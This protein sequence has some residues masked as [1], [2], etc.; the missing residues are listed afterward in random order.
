MPSPY[1]HCVKK[2]GILDEEILDELA[3]TI[4]RQHC[5]L[6]I[7]LGLADVDEKLPQRDLKEFL[8]RVV[9]WCVEN[10]VI[11]QKEIADNFKKPLEKEMLEAGEL[12]K[13]ELRTLTEIKVP[14]IV[15]EWYNSNRHEKAPSQC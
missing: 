15:V 14:V 8:R 7:G 5:A 13:V 12:E 9:Q 3:K 4:R 11:T 6:L 2:E 10:K 1:R